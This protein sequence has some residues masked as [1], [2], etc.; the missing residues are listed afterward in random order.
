M[1]SATRASTEEGS[2]ADRDRDRDQSPAQPGVE[3]T[4]RANLQRLAQPTSSIPNIGRKAL[5][6]EPPLELKS[7][8]LQNMRNRVF[9]STRPHLASPFMLGQE[10]NG[11]GGGEGSGGG[12]G[13]RL[14]TREGTEGEF[15]LTPQAY[16]LGPMTNGDQ[17]DMD[18]LNQYYY[19]CCLPETPS[20]RDGDR[21]SL[22]ASTPRQGGQ[23]RGMRV[24]GGGAAARQRSRRTSSER[25]SYVSRPFSD[26][27]MVVSSDTELEASAVSNPRY[28]HSVDTGAGMDRVSLPAILAESPDP[29][30]QQNEHG[31]DAFLTQRNR[32]PSQDGS[33]ERRKRHIVIDMPHIIF[34]APTP[35]I[36]VHGAG[37]G[38]RGLSPPE[39]PGVLSKTLKQN[40]IRHRELQNL[41]ED[42]KELNKRT[43]TLNTQAHNT[44]M[45][46]ASSMC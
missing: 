36:S 44:E 6:Q 16:K 18:K 45:E 39:R 2:R 11:G 14:D 35:D 24:G 9:R 29:L 17:L 15:H 20:T 8:S 34:N 10:D 23:R 19:I 28:R 13:G 5:R 31:H 30:L 37:K 7:Q 43:E 3:D 41:L 33:P 25:S 46:A 38:N 12:G 21:K 42:V 32:S 27:S 1:C 26:R 4:V 22:V 40:E